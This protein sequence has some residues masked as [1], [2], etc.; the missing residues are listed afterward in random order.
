MPRAP[1]PSMPHTHTG[2]SCLLS[3]YSA[4]P[5]PHCTHRTL[6]RNVCVLQVPVELTPS[7]KGSDAQS[8]TVKKWV[9]THEPASLPSRLTVEEEFK[10]DAVLTADHLERLCASR[11]ESSDPLPIIAVSAA[12]E[13]P[14]APDPSARTLRAIANELAGKWD[15]TAP[16]CGMPLFNA[17]GFDDVG[18]FFSFSSLYQPPRTK[19]KETGF[20]RALR[21]SALWFA[22]E[23]TTAYVV[24][25]MDMHLEGAPRQSRG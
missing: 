1:L 25:G 13:Q 21:S 14:G 17:H 15:G 12:W 23:R 7:F 9:A 19:A 24:V 8:V 6:L 4:L 2:Q 3:Y 11:A 20:Q 10:Q 5:Y 16:T 22:H 18:V